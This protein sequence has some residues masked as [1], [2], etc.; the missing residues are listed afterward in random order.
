MQFLPLAAALLNNR[1]VLAMFDVS[2]DHLLRY[3]H[4]I[5]HVTATPPSLDI[6]AEWIDDLHTNVRKWR[7][8]NGYHIVITRDGDVQSDK[9]GD[10]C[11]PLSVHGAHVGSSGPGWN[12]RSLGIVLVGGVDEDNRP[13]FNITDQQLESLKFVLRLFWRKHPRPWTLNLMGHRDLIKQTGA[14]AKACP[15][16]D[17]QEWARKEGVFSHFDFQGDMEDA[18]QDDQSLMLIPPTYKIQFGDTLWS[19]AEKF[20]LD[21]NKLR[22]LNDTAPRSLRPGQS[23]RLR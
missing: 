13:E 3:D 10:P 17:V 5:V 9:L 7:R 18:P 20:G 4:V 23:I 19:V 15:C 16:F 2:P 6:D 1:P 21:L 12:T 14:P 8:G 22:S 11:R